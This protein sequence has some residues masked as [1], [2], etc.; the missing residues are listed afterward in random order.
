MLKNARHLSNMGDTMD[1]LI[2]ERDGGCKMQ[3]YEGC[4]IGGAV[5]DA[6]GWPVEF[7]SY[8]DIISKYGALG[9]TDLILG[10]G[11]KAEIT[12]D[13]QMAVF[14]AEGLLR[15][16]ARICETTGNK[17]GDCNILDYS[18]IAVSV[19]ESYRRWLY[20]Q[21]DAIPDKELLNGWII[22][23]KELFHR[24]APGG[25]CLSALR[26]GRMG[27]MENPI[28]NSKGCGGIMRAAPVGL[29]IDCEHAF[30]TGA[31]I[32]AITHGHPSGYLAAGAL[33]K[34]ISCIIAGQDLQNAANEAAEELTQYEGSEE[35][36]NALKNALALAAEGS[37]SVEKVSSLGEGWVA[38]EAL[39]ISVYC[40][41]SYKN[42]FRKA[43]LLAVN[44]NGDSDSTGA[45]TGNILGAYLGIQGIPEE[46]T[47]RVELSAEL[48]ELAGDLEKR[49]RDH[50]IWRY[51]YP[52]VDLE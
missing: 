38:E 8:K 2:D 19:Y 39:A 50:E 23:I 14:T 11:M 10:I 48:R 44:H 25:S 4:L 3:R 30:K 20:T 32:A 40:A 37:P 15:A 9:I 27:T 31:E 41:L 35:C 6:L 16:F 7:A 52:G 13:T 45:I 18:N 49:Y 47:Y 26:S 42:D 17:K 21:G 12:D 36:S 34:I 1:A 29:I 22:G 43:V 33:A 51:K 5:G 46:W 24:R 28:N